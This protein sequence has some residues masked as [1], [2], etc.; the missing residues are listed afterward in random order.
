MSEAKESLVWG[1]VFALLGLK[2]TS[3]ERLIRGT[4]FINSIPL[5]TI[6]E[7]GVTHSFILLDSDERLGLK[8]S[9]MVRSMVVD[10]PTLV[11][12]TTL[13]VWL[14]CPLTIFGKNF[15]MDL[16]CLPLRNLDAILGMNWLE[17]N[18]VHINCYNKTLSFPEFVVSD[19]L[20]VFAKQVDE[21]VKDDTEVN[22]LL[23]SM[24]AESKVVI[25]ELPV[26]CDFS[27][28]FPD[29]ISD[30]PPERKVE[31]TID[32]VPGT[33]LMSI[34]PY[35]MSTSESSEMKK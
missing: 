31:F 15:G 6:I 20:F 13:W 25:G 1:K 34:T 33:S 3:S 8:L 23:D 16:V 10:T 4:C 27:K 32:L 21:F 26:V 19:E 7:M 24:K 30:F 35:R 28:V 29:D 9:Y 5:I 18:H 2:T 14:N 11:P 22:M 17:F 12:I